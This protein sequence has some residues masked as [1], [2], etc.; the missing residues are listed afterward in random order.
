MIMYEPSFRDAAIAALSLTGVVRLLVWSFKPDKP[1]RPVAKG[2][3]TI[4][5]FRTDNKVIRRSTKYKQF[6]LSVLK[7]DGFKCLWCGETG[8]LEVD[9]IKPFAYFPELRFVLSNARTL[10]PNCHRKTNTYGHKAKLLYGHI[11]NQNN[12]IIQSRY[13]LG[14]NG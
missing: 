6:R 2:W 3:K 13:S 9:H 11:K 1:D 4:D 12:S 14:K 5:E 10:C 8:Y 7:R